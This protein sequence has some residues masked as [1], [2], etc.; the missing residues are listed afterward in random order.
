MTRWIVCL[1]ISCLSLPTFAIAI[2]IPPGQWQCMAVDKKEKNYGAFGKSMNAAR[3]AAKADCRRRSDI[4]RT[5][6]T[7]QSYCEQGPVSLIENRCIVTDESG[8]TWNTTGRNACRTAKYLCQ[9]WQYLHGSTRSVCTIKH[10][11]RDY[12]RNRKEGKKDETILE[13][14]IGDND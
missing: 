8:R 6:R 4:P 2:D 12:D 1:L 7:A 10:R 9:Q 11:M 3:R 14:L 5:C 13:K